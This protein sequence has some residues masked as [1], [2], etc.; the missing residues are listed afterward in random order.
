MYGF[1]FVQESV[2]FVILEIDSRCHPCLEIDD[3][4]IERTG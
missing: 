2:S 1:P 4:R 3:D